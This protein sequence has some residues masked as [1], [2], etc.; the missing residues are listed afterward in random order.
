M[1]TDD[2]TVA[3]QVDGRTIICP[4]SPDDLS[5]REAFY[6]GIAAHANRAPYVTNAYG[7]WQLGWSCRDQATRN[8]CT[9]VAVELRDQLDHMVRWHD[10]LKDADIAKARVLLAKTEVRTVT[11]LA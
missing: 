7:A 10:Q 8:A 3:S 1:T 5:R 11:A 4:Y 2:P 6:Q 9:A